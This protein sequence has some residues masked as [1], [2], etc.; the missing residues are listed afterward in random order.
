MRLSIRYFVHGSN[1]KRYEFVVSTYLTIHEVRLYIIDNL[2]NR[3]ISH[4]FIHG[5]PWYGKEYDKYLCIGV[6][7]ETV[8]GFCTLV[9]IVNCVYGFYDVQMLSTR[10]CANATYFCEEGVF[11]PIDYFMDAVSDC[12][13]QKLLRRVKYECY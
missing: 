5:E 12:L 8:S 10:A 1:I 13:Y 9:D 2:N 7:D 6:S 4:Y 11:I 3:M